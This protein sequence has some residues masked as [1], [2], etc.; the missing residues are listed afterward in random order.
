MGGF[1]SDPD[2]IGRFNVTAMFIF[3]II[4]VPV[5]SINRLLRGLGLSAQKTADV[6]STILG[7]SMPCSS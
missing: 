3:E 1:G 2:V 5:E 4:K 6:G 7:R